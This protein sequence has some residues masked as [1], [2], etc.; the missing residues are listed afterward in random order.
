LLF[1]SACGLAECALVVHAHA[2]PREWIVVFTKGFFLSLI[3]PALASSRKSN[4]V[5]CVLR[6]RG[7]KLRHSLRRTLAQTRFVYYLFRSL[8]AFY[9]TG[10]L[11]KRRLTCC[12]RES[13][14]I[15]ACWL[16]GVL[17]PQS[18]GQPDASARATATHE[19]CDHSTSV[20]PA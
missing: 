10:A 11:A 15:K 14:Q 8:L 5:S 13:T 9:R 19:R 12:V 6:V 1:M 7:G 20:V 18:F 16:C 4:R 2:P 17:S 3:R